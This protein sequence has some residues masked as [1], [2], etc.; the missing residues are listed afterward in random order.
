M[1]LVVQI[2]ELTAYSSK[3]MPKYF[4]ETE[5]EEHLNKKLSESL[6]QSHTN[7][8]IKLISAVSNIK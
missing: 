2:I 3:N 4:T 8:L 6:N 5:R 7:Y 1:T